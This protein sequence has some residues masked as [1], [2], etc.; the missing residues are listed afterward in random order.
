MIHFICSIP[1]DDIFAG[2][3]VYESFDLV[4]SG[5]KNA[6]LSPEGKKNLRSFKFNFPIKHIKKVFTAPMGQ[7]HE[8]GKLIV[9]TRTNEAPLHSVQ[10]LINIRFRM[11][12]LLSRKEFES[13]P[14][15]EAA[16]AAR[17]AFAEKFFDGALSENRQTFENRIRILLKN[18]SFEKG[19][20]L[21]IGHAFHLKVMEIYLNRPFAFQNREDFI[22]A[23]EP[24]R[25][26][27]APL[28]GFSISQARIAQRL[29]E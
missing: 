2:M 26:P 18:L 3:S 22:A 25:R 12:D 10:G 27:F 28:E 11:A 6:P 13:L 4:S 8:S 7:T 1:V 15:G 17:Q 19:E 21:C 23:F 9:A 5:E 16:N 20:L 29:R 14:Y 24:A